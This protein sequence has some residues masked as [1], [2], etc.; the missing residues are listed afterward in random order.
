MEAQKGSGISGSTLKTIAVISMLT[1]HVAAVLLGYVLTQKGVYSVANI[2]LKY[3]WEFAQT[4]M[5]GRA[6]FA[7]QIMRRV[8]GRL[9]FPLFCFLLVEGFEKTRSR[10]RYAIRLLGFALISEIPFD[11]AFRREIFNPT[12]QNV[13]FTLLLGFLMMWAME[14]LERRWK[15]S[16]LMIAVWGL[17]FAAAFLAEW[18]CCDYGAHGMIA[19]ALLYLFRRDRRAQIIAGCIA[20]LWEVTAPLAF[21]FIAFYNGKKG[22]GSKYFFYIFYP[23][24]LLVCHFLTLFL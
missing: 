16:P 14:E 18:G 8:I 3:M 9:A 6:Y 21:I 24:H 15:G 12:Y 20:F 1:D 19:I 13:M 17:V 23:A 7:Y 11:L 5:T 4:G 22:R 10:T 2:S